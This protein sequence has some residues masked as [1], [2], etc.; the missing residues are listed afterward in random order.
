MLAAGHH[1]ERG[2]R[3]ASEIGDRRQRSEIVILPV[4]DVRRHAPVYR[5]LPHI[6]Q[7][8]L[9]QRH[10]LDVLQIDDGGEMKYAAA[11]SLPASAHI[12]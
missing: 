7:M 3:A 12:A 2:S 10:A 4:E 8:L 11:M 9:V 6:A 1:L 5:M